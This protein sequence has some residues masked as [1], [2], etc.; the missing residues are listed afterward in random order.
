[1]TRKEPTAAPHT[2]PTPPIV[3]MMR[4]WIESSRSRVC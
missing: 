3:A 2:V 1:M 4:I